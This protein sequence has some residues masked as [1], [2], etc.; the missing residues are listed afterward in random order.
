VY[1]LADLAEKV[2]LVSQ[3]AEFGHKFPLKQ[4]APFEFFRYENWDFASYGLKKP[5]IPEI[6]M[7]KPPN[8]LP[9]AAA[10]ALYKFLAFATID[11]NAPPGFD[12]FT[13]YYEKNMITWQMY[14]TE[15]YLRHLYVIH[16]AVPAEDQKAVLPALEDEM[17]RHNRF[18]DANR[19]A[20]TE[21]AHYTRE[22]AVPLK[23]VADKLEQTRSALTNHILALFLQKHPQV[24][25][26]LRTVKHDV[27]AQKSLFKSLFGSALAKLKKFIQAFGEFILPDVACQLH[28]YILQILPF[29]EYQ[30][31]HHCK[32]DRCDKHIL[33][34]AEQCI[35]RACVS[36]A[37]ERV[38]SLFQCPELFTFAIHTLRN[39]ASVEIPLEALTE[40]ANCIDLLTDL[41]I[42]EMDAPPTSKE[43]APLFLFALL[44]SRTGSIFSLC[45]YLGHYLSDLLAAEVPILSDRL[46]QALLQFLEYLDLLDQILS[47]A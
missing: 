10:A 33:D 20:L 36:P 29:S 12:A 45:H 13:E 5:P 35:R 4:A 47:D 6:E 21:L 37:P 39:A 24:L 19:R 31:F 1:L 26:E 38:R 32:F 8:L 22:L 14:D 44:M 11:K 9:S 18:I 3:L 41:Y 40:V 7:E 27:H 2:G 23:R 43:L 28:S 15:I 30:V 46:R 17:R 16:K 34:H 25:T 42:L